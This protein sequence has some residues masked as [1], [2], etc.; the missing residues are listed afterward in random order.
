[1]LWGSGRSL[2][3]LARGVAASGVVLVGA[4]FAA[5]QLIDS[6]LVPRVGALV[7]VWLLFSAIS[8]VAANVLGQ[9]GRA[10]ASTGLLPVRA[11]D[12]LLRL[13]TWAVAPAA[14]IAACGGV[15]VAASFG[16]SC[17]LFAWLVAAGLL[18][19]TIGAGALTSVLWPHPVAPAGAGAELPWAPGP[20]RLVLSLAH[21]AILLT[22]ASGMSEGLGSASVAVASGAVT[23]AVGL[24]VASRTLERR[25]CSVMEALLR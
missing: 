20:P 25:R 10:G 6:P 18:G 21:G 17:G 13:E 5:R 9:G 24:A 2:S 8:P 4:S 1:V 11:F 15:L 12:S 3:A 7:A 22:A 23:A 16:R 14:L 19:A